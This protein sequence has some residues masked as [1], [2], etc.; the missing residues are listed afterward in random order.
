MWSKMCVTEQRGGAKGSASLLA[1]HHPCRRVFVVGMGSVYSQIQTDIT[2]IGSVEFRSLY[3]G[4]EQMATDPFSQGPNRAT[5]AGRQSESPSICTSLENTALLC[6]LRCE[7]ATQSASY[8]SD[9]WYFAAGA[10]QFVQI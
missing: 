6:S 5:A 9:R 1:T 8:D 3:L 4:P 10:G 7:H 2:D